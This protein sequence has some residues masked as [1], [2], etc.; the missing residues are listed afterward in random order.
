MAKQDNSVWD[1]FAA[2]GFYY[3]TDPSRPGVNDSNLVDEPAEAIKKREEDNAVNKIVSSALDIPIGISAKA[4]E[5]AGT[6]ANFISSKIAETGKSLKEIPGVN[7]INDGLKAI[8]ANNVLNS[9]ANNQLPGA[10]AVENFV[11]N[12]INSIQKI[13]A[14]PWIGKTLALPATAIASSMKAIM[15][16]SWDKIVDGITVQLTR[17]LLTEIGQVLIDWYKDPKTLCC[18]IKNLAAIGAMLHSGD[19]TEDSWDQERQKFFAGVRTEDYLGSDYFRARNTLINLRDYLDI[20]IEVLS[21]QFDKTLFAGFD[22][23]KEISD[24]II[25]LMIGVLDALT[26][27]GKKAWYDKVSEW[28]KD[29]LQENNQ[30]LPFQKLIDVLFRFFSS[31]HGL[32]NILNR[33]IKDYARYLKWR[34]INNFKKKYINRTRDLQFLRFLRDLINKIIDSL[35]NFEICV[36]NDYSVIDNPNPLSDFQISRDLCPFGQSSR[37]TNGWVDCPY[38]TLSNNDIICRVNSQIPNQG[39][40]SYCLHPDAINEY[41]GVQAY[42]R[43][44]NI[45]NIE[46]DYPGA[47]RNIGDK[48]IAVIFPTN[49]EVRNFMVNKLGFSKDQ[50]DQMVAESISSNKESTIDLGLNIGIKDNSFESSNGLKTNISEDLINKRKQ[51]MSSLGDC[52]KTLSP[53]NIADLANKLSDIF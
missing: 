4:G 11:D 43:A 48:E 12:R 7:K 16:D 24:M 40:T 36:E 51:L 52:A 37:A 29:L 5:I 27:A 23:G 28:F 2:K 17:D 46:G 9:L 10:D 6:S 44:E 26:A 30:C 18:L 21:I 47:N 35:E 45:G 31:D 20:I 14:A 1:K 33:Y 50:A 49:N 38:R 41:F 32:F 15:P 13:K 42:K 39:N 19:F 34:F 53:Q 3:H 22:I 25:G 8:D